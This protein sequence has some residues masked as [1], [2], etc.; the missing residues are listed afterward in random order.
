M[1]DYL[2]ACILSSKRVELFTDHWILVG[3]VNDL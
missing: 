1:S 3:K 2:Y